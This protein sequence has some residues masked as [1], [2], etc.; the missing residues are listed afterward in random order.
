[1]CVFVSLYFDVKVDA[2]WSDVFQLSVVYFVG[3][4]GFVSSS[5]FMKMSGEHWV[6]NVNLTS[7]LFTCMYYLHG[8][9]MCWCVCM[10][11]R[12]DL[13]FLNFFMFVKK[14]QFLLVWKRKNNIC[15]PSSVCDTDCCHHGDAEMWDWNCDI[16]NAGL[17]N[18]GSN[19]VGRKCRTKHTHTT[20]LQPSWILSR[21]TGWADTRNVK[22]GR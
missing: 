2:L 16:K 3:I 22:P 7:A 14:M 15:C 5:M 13:E 6:S 1:M 17:E 4:S 20:I 9:Y 19:C 8:V 18:P 11:G 10:L 21:T 12:K